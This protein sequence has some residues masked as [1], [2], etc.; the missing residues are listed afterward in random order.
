MV[1]INAVFFDLGGVLLRTE[2]HTPRQQLAARLGITYGQLA[3]LIFNSE[4]ARLA[5]LGK[6]NAEAHWEQIRL[7]LGLAPAEFLAARQAFWDGDRLDMRLIQTIR[8]LRT[9]RKTALLSNAWDDLRSYIENEWK[10]ADAFDEMIISAEV[11]LAK[12]DPRIYQY[13][14]DRLSFQPRECVLLDDFI[15]NVEG[16]RS[17]GMPAIHFKDRFSAL[18]ELEGLLE[19]P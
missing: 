11:G 7:S 2:D 12:P 10:F 14:A 18:E 8:T 6:I 4:T 17:I 16:A 13:A 3:E 15:E 1:K 5:T 19:S 9:S